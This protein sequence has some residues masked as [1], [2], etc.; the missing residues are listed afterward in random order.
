MFI[1]DI[2]ALYKQ[3]RAEHKEE[4]AKYKLEKRLIKSPFDY[5]LLEDFLRVYCDTNHRNLH[6]TCTSADGIKVDIFFDKEKNDWNHK[7][8]IEH[9]MRGE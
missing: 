2:L 1:K 5:R 4:I 9:I 3:Y 6:I 8:A 7:T